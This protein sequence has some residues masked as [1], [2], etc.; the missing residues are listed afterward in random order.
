MKI[1]V[2]GAIINPE[3]DWE[4]LYNRVN[5]LQFGKHGPFDLV[6]II[7]SSA[8]YTIPEHLKFPL[9]IVL[10]SGIYENLSIQ[11]VSS[12]TA[13]QSEPTSST[14]STFVDVLLTDVLPTNS[15]CPHSL[16]TNSQLNDYVLNLAPR[17]H[18]SGGSLTY[19]QRA[20]YRNEK[21][22][23]YTRLVTLCSVGTAKEK[24]IHAVN[25]GPEASFTIEP[26]GTTDNPYRSVTASTSTNSTTKVAANAPSSASKQQFFFAQEDV[27]RSS[28]KRTKRD[29]L[30][31]AADGKSK[32]PRIPPRQD[33]WFCL[34]SSACEKHLLAYIGDETYIA[35]PKG[36]IRKEHVL[37]IPISHEQSF[38]DFLNIEG[39]IAEV[40]KIQ[41]K[42]ETAFAKAGYTTLY[43]DRSLTFGKAPQLHGYLEVLP[44]PLSRLEGIE[45]AFRAEADM[46][47]LSF[48]QVGKGVGAS[49]DDNL[50]EIRKLK[51]Y[52]FV[53][54][55]GGK[56]FVHQAAK[57]NV[58]DIRKRTTLLN[59]GR[60]IACKL[61]GCP[62][63]SNW[64]SCV[65]SH[66]QEESWTK[67]LAATI[68]AQ[69]PEQ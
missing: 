45:A 47:G 39:S 62:E 43:V 48:E 19:F 54:L 12:S 25:I 32:A 5:E 36:G 4:I 60:I 3:T 14:G 28:A 46:S 59:F 11:V 2:S 15:G 35:L 8:Q 30:N 9:P 58:E 29:H 22:Q 61:L 55:P 13:S 6:L 1:L 68:N 7:P 52:L 56:A 41:S 17:Y 37:I 69:E 44:V 57:D 26:P 42:V 49:N 10:D 64:K 24:W 21:G 31:S 65:A 67:S 63:R 40:A 18:F 23:P 27:D 66:A 53:Q 51:E 34:A 16:H 20:P 38:A 50:S 33:C